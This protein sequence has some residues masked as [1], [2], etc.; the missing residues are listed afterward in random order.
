MTVIELM[1]DIEKAA[2]ERQSDLLNKVRLM[3]AKQEREEA[4]RTFVARLRNWPTFVPSPW[5]A[6]KMAAYRT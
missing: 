2:V 4:V 5:S 6:Q 1:A 3:D